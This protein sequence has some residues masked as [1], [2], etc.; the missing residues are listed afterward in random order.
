MI[1][2]NKAI[3]MELEEIQQDN[4]RN[5]LIKAIGIDR[6]NK[7]IYSIH[8]G[9][10]PLSQSGK[11]MDTYSVQHEPYVFT[12]NRIILLDQNGEEIDTFENLNVLCM[13]SS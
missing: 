12:C 1:E 9:L 3:N 7:G 6:I 4:T 13:H 11:D 2:A 5:Q 10:P 8:F